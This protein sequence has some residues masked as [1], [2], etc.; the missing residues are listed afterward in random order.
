MGWEE[1]G[2]L[3]PEYVKTYYDVCVGKTFL[4]FTECCGRR[5]GELAR[6]WNVDSTID[7]DGPEL[8]LLLLLRLLRPLTY[9]CLGTVR[10]CLTRSARSVRRVK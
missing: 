2:D 5:G 6:V 1:G 4:R 10:G 7:V 9:G 3:A 8:L